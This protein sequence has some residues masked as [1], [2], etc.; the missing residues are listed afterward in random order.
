[1]K[2]LLLGTLAHPEYRQKNCGTCRDD[3][4]RAKAE[5]REDSLAGHRPTSFLGLLPPTA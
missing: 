3:E 1:V 5:L 4:K 2:Q